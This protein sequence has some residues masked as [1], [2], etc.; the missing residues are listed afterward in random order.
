MTTKPTKPAVIDYKED[1][2]WNRF[3]KDEVLI[4]QLII[5]KKYL[6][7]EDSIKGHAVSML[8][9]LVDKLICDQI[10]MISEAKI[11]Y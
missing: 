5:L 8:D 7:N 6:E 11:P 3:N 1:A 10:D 4:S 2:I 9:G